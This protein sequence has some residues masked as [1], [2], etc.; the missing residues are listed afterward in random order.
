M[1]G[2]G[3]ELT[4]EG[5]KKRKDHIELFSCA[6]GTRTATKCTFIAY[7]YMYVCMCVRVACFVFMQS[8][9]AQNIKLECRRQERK[10]SILL[11]AGIKII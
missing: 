11:C 1:G 9:F 2:E 4:V 7:I 8:S 6:S 5:Y 3:I 10:R